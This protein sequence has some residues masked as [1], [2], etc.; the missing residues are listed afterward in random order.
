MYSDLSFR[1]GE[2][3]PEAEPSGVGLETLRIEQTKGLSDFISVER[4]HTPYLRGPLY[5]ENLCIFVLVVELKAL[6]SLLSPLEAS[7]I[8]YPSP[9][10]KA[11]FR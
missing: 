2:Q 5:Q 9:H 1:G 7:D 6:S 11:A 10:K 8:I 3:G 4:T